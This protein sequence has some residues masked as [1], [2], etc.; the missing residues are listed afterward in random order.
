MKPLSAVCG[1]CPEDK[2][3][4]TAADRKAAEA[5]CGAM[6]QIFSKSSGFACF[7]SLPDGLISD[8]NAWVECQAGER[9]GA[10]NSV[11]LGSQR[12][13]IP[14]AQG[15]F[16]FGTGGNYGAVNHPLVPGY[17]AETGKS[18]GASPVFYGAGGGASAL[19]PGFAGKF[20]ICEKVG[21]FAGY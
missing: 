20:K 13:E 8:V 5:M 18:R 7:R 6:F 3:K 12:P 21:N 2:G 4:D 16:G 10:G 15:F 11:R 19:I 14:T 9:V 17:G 1:I